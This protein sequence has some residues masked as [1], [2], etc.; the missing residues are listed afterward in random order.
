V[1]VATAPRGCC[2]STPGATRRRGDTTRTAT[3]AE[4]A[5][6]R[7]HAVAALRERAHLTNVA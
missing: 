1:P 3:L 4:L 6:L 7:D 2:A 5:G